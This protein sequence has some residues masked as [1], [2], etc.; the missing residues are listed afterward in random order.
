MMEWVQKVWEGS[1]YVWERVRERLWVRG[2]VRER[3][4]VPVACTFWASALCAAVWPGRPSVRVRVSAVVVW[5]VRAKEVARKKGELLAE[6][7]LRFVVE[8]GRE[9]PAFEY[10][11]TAGCLS[12]QLWVVG[13]LW[14]RKYGRGWWV[15]VFGRK[16][17]LAASGF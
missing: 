8:E 6:A 12:L 1:I 7:E 16:S 3:A 2:V 17:V 10:Y 9:V 13:W 14:G 11:C 15:S 5:S 4:A